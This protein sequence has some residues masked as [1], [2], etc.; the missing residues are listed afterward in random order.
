[1]VFLLEQHQERQTK[2]DSRACDEIHDANDQKRHA[3]EGLQEIRD[4]K[5][6]RQRRILIFSHP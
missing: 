1:M 6:K 4:Y 5:K 2:D 3:R